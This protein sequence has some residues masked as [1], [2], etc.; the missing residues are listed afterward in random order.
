MP[1]VDQFARFQA[2]VIS[3]LTNAVAVTPHNTNE[4]GYVTRAVYVGGT[5]DLKVTLQDSGTVTFVDVPAGST[6]AI[7]AKVVFSTG[8]TAT[9]IVALW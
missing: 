8:T 5:G 7:R 1:A 3:P 4:L 9:D 2:S 6:L